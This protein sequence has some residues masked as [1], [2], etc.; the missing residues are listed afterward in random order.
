[1]GV[2]REMGRLIRLAYNGHIS[3]TELTGYIYALDKTRVCLESAIAIDAAEKAAAVANAPHV[4]LAV[5]VLAVPHGYCVTTET[6]M[7]LREDLPQ[8]TQQLEQQAAAA[9]PE[10]YPPPVQLDEP[11]PPAEPEPREPNTVLKLAAARGYQPL[12]RRVG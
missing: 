10:A 3:H 8:L 6:A 4:P 1:M 11:P 2:A 9:Q 7:R 5:A 12:P